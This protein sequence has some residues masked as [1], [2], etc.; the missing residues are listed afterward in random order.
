MKKLDGQELAGVAEQDR[1]TR[2]SSS[3]NSS[4]RTR[5]RSPS[6]D[7]S[8]GGQGGQG[9]RTDGQDSATHVADSSDG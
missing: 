3:A 4:G 8:R 1:P 2:P 6:W 7:E 5:C 9:A